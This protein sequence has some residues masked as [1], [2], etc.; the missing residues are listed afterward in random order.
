MSPRKQNLLVISAEDL[1]AEIDQPRGKVDPHKGEV[2]LQRAA[3]PS[4]DCQRLRPIDQIFLWD[5]GP[6]A[7]ESPENLQAAPYHH[8]QRNCIQPVTEPNHQRML[9]D[10]P[11]DC[12][13]LFTARARNFDRRFVHRESIAHC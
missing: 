9:V 1:I 4:T 7:R 5:F 13:S 3:Q 12:L 10:R 6:E 11:P 8:E 2:P